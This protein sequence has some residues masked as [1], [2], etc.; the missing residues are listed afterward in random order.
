MQYAPPCTLTVIP[1]FFC[2][3]KKRV[4]VSIKHFPLPLM[5]HTVPATRTW[6]SAKAE[7]EAEHIPPSRCTLLLLLLQSNIEIGGRRPL[8][9]RIIV[10]AVSEIVS[11]IVV[12][13]SPKPLPWGTL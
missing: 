3:R 6:K 5:G 11:V 9:G 13:G 2:E 10:T 1:S 12:P 8:E 4:S 7:D